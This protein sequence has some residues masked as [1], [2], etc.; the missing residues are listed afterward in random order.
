MALKLK[1]YVRI[2]Y[3]PLREPDAWLDC[4][5]TLQKRLQVLEENLDSTQIV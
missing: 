3:A 1:I 5:V 2:S 4:S